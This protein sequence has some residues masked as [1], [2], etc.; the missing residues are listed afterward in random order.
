MKTFSLR[1]A[2]IVLC[3]TLVVGFVQPSNA[4]PKVGDRIGD[5]NFLCKALSEKQNVCALIQTLI[6]SETKEKVLTLVLR[7]VGKDRKLALFA[8]APLGIYL[9]AGIAGKIDDG[10]PF[11]FSWQRCTTKGCQA[12]AVVDAELEKALKAG[13]RLMIGFEAQPN[14][15]TVALDASL[16]GLASGLKALDKE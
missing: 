9:D 15:Q 3:A 13:N 12:V 10:K 14:A 6:N 1:I 11:T 2:P 16:K 7:R 4:V 8:T 5:W